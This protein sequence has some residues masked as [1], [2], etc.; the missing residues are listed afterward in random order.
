MMFKQ[1][2]YVM[3]MM[4]VYVMA[5]P[6][7]E[8]TDSVAAGLEAAGLDKQADIVRSADGHGG[9]RGGGGD[10]GGVTGMVAD[11]LAAADLG[12]IADIVRVSGGGF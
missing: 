7:P 10:G 11:G 12:P 2:L 4:T 1:C 8:D 9:S 3:T 5:A 6:V